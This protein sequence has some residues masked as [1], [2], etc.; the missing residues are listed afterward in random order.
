M[1]IPKSGKPV[2]A[3]ALHAEMRAAVPSFIGL[4]E[5][6]EEIIANKSDG[7]EFSPAEQLTLINVLNN[8]NQ[9]EI[10]ATREQRLK[11]MRELRADVVEALKNWAALTAAEK[12][13]AIHKFMILEMEGK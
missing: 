13:E 10:I 5:N 12:I 9:A 4:T 7:N 11:K 1:R 3:I 8:H 2:D 6:K